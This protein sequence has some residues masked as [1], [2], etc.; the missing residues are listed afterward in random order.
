MINK[1]LGSVKTICTRVSSTPVKSAPRLAIIGDKA[2][3]D[4]ATEQSDIIPIFIFSL[5]IVTSPTSFITMTIL[6]GMA[7]IEYLNDFC[8]LIFYCNKKAGHL[9]DNL[10]FAI[11]ILLSFQS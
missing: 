11:I 6:I 10:L 9:I 8:N 2:I 1:R 3:Y 5:F 4:K 7:H